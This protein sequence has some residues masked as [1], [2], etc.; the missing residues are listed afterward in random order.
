LRN[1]TRHPG[2]WGLPGGKV[3]SGETLLGAMERE[4]I[5]ELGSMP[6]YQRLVPLEKF[7]SSD[8]QFEYNTWV[9]VVADEFVPV[10]NAEHMGYAWIDRGQWPRPMHPGLWSTVNIEAVQSKIDTVERYLALSS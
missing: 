9:C 7:T 6:E 10:L 8:G 5:E 3:E 2:S 1:D 4:C